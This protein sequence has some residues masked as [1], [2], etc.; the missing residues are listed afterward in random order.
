MAS[1][2]CTY[3]E[4]KAFEQFGSRV[5]RKPFQLLEKCQR[6][7]SKIVSAAAKSDKNYRMTLCLE[8]IHESYNLIHNVRKAN[9]FPLGGEDRKVSQAEAKENIERIYDLIPVMRKCQCIT[10][11]QEGDIE[12][13]LCYVRASFDYWLKSDESRIKKLNAKNGI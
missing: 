8:V 4:E 11:Q 3:S 5:K 1:K 7:S 9:F 2:N 13:D 10:P 12:K 6:L